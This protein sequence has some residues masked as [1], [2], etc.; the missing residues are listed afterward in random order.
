MLLTQE[1]RA[2]GRED[3]TRCPFEQLYDRGATA[4]KQALHHRHTRLQDE[5][6]EV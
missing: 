1:G 4:R 6:R 2:R 3:A 5:R